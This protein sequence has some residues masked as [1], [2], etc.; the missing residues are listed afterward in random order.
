MGIEYIDATG[1]CQVIPYRIMIQLDS[2]IIQQ[3]NGG[4]MD[5]AGDLMLGH[6]G[7]PYPNLSGKP[8]GE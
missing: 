6:G 2:R 8:V 3:T 7:I 4:I 5:F 1:I